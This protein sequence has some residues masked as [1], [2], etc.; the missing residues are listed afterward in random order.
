MAVA[1][2]RAADPGAPDSE[3]FGRRLTHDSQPWLAAPVTRRRSID[4]RSAR[5]K[6]RPVVK[7]VS[8]AGAS[9]ARLALFVVLFVAL[10]AAGIAWG[11]RSS[12]VV[13]SDLGVL[14]DLRPIVLAALIALCVGLYAA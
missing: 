5:S 4:R 6:D 7:R 9:Y 1:I 3:R 12:G 10:A 14:W 2:R 13:P 11:V 8:A